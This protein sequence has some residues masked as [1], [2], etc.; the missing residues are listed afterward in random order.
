MAF[1]IKTHHRSSDTTGSMAETSSTNAY[2]RDA[3]M[4]A[5]PEQLQLML[6][7]GAIRFASQGRDAIEAD[8]YE[9]VYNK[10]SRAQ[11]IVLEMQQGLNRDVAPDLC[12]RMS[13][14]Y[15]YIYRRLVDGCVN[16]DA[17]AVDDA[18]KLLRFERDTWVMLI[19]KLTRERG[20]AAAAPVSEV[21]AG[22]LAIEG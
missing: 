7:D 11:R 5:S 14:L 8:Q 17:N 12:D 10:L 13:A 2:L 22:S 18:I 6:Y 21:E 9:D 4:T 19:E 16:R 1:S 15:S 20:G 3:V